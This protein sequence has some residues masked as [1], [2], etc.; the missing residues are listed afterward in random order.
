MLDLYIRSLLSRQ[1]EKDY[2]LTAEST[3]I[4]KPMGGFSTQIGGKIAVPSVTFSDYLFR[5]L[6]ADYHQDCTF[7]LSRSTHKALT[8]ILVLLHRDL[9][10][11]CTIRS[12][13]SILCPCTITS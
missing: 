5:L 8:L 3:R 9:P 12:D 6:Y 1:S 13:S 10:Y 4:Y 7:L 11:P 2:G